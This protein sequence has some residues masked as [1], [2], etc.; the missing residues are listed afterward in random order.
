MDK[1]NQCPVI[2]ENTGLRCRNDSRR[3]FW[4]QYKGMSIRTKIC[5]KC[6]E[7]SKGGD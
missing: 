2:P 7:Q 6:Y 3:I 5:N 1:Y 4:V